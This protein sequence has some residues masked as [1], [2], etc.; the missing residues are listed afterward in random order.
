M[1]SRKLRTTRRAILTGASALLLS[2]VFTHRACA[3]KLKKLSL[4]ISAGNAPVTL[5]EFVRQ[6]GLQ[7]LF[8][9]DAIRT[10]T[11]REINGRHDPREALSLMFEGSDLT[12]EF[13]NP[14]TIAVRPRVPE[15][16]VI[17]QPG[18]TGP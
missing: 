15:P 11:T 13:I 8:D 5:A 16:T 12:F 10:A 14:R 4:H 2:S 18:P 9:F 7:V 1:P 17:A 6:T 3:D